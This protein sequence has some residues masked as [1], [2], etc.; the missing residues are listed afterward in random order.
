VVAAEQSWPAV[1]SLASIFAGTGTGLALAGPP[2]ALVGLLLTS[3]GAIVVTAGKSAAQAFGPKV[4]ERAA[5]VVTGEDK[6]RQKEY[7]DAMNEIEKL[8]TAK[9]IGP[10]DAKEMRKRVFERYKIA[11]P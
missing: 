11:A 7:D 1:G 6:R 8:E 10:D 4:G 2:G 9:K 5:A 3:V